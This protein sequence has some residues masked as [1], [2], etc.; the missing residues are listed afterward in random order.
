MVVTVDEIKRKVQLLFREVG[1]SDYNSNLIADALLDADMNGNTSHGIRMAL[2]HAKKFQLCYSKQEKITVVKNYPSVT[3]CDANNMMGIISACQCMEI[4]LSKAKSN[5]AHIVF[6]RN[7]NTFSA[8]SYYVEM[9]VK[10]KMVGIAICNSPAQMAPVGGLDRLFGTNP[11]AIGFPG[12][13]DDSFIFDMATS[14]VAKS[15]INEV[16]D[17]GGDYIP[18]GWATDSNG[19]P[20]TDP[21]KAQTGIISPLG[22]VKG[23]GLSASIDLLAGCLGGAAFLNDVGRFYPISNP[24]MN[25]GHFFM[26]IDPKLIGD[27][28]FLNKFS[29][30]YKRIRNSKNIFGQTVY[31]PGDLAKISKKRA[32]E[33]GLDYPDRIIE[34]IDTFIDSLHNATLLH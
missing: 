11:I 8:A 3:V 6:C 28:N 10:E 27:E 22:G 26:A 29:E 17:K 18:L 15:K 30:Y 16:I 23:Y 9:A 7:A 25:V 13:H 14:A 12:E 19:I 2:D 20:T 4:A 32:I 5:G 1:V 31:I 21:R 34:D 33:N 24:G